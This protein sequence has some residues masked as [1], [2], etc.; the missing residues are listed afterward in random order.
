MKLQVYRAATALGG[1]LIRLYLARRRARG[2]EDAARFGER[3]GHPGR[4]RPPGPL[5]WLHGASVGESLSL[6]PLV[7]R[8]RRDLPGAAALVTTGTVTSARLMAER[9]PEGAFHQYVPVDRAAWVRTFLDH[10]RP[11]LIL[12]SESEFWPNLLCEPAAR[13]IPM[14]L[15]NGRVS[16]RALATWR[17]HRGL[18]RHLLAGFALCLGQSPRDAER[19]RELGAPRVDCL[20]NLKQAAAPLP[21]DAADLAALDAALDGRP[22]WLAASTHAGEEALAGRVHR[23]LA[24]RHPGLLT[25]VVPRH[26]DRGA[27]VAADLRRQGL[28]VA[29][30]GGGEAPAA[31]TDVLLADTLGELGLFYRLGGVAF[32]GKS[33]L[34]EGGQNPLEPAQLGCAVLYGPHMG[35]F[36]DTV[37]GLEAAGAAQAVADEAALA[38]AV[39]RLLAD[40]AERA[41]RAAAGAAFATARSAVLDDV[42]AALEPF[43]APL[44]AAAPEPTRAG[45]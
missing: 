40:P 44:R 41:R 7:Q 32:V 43:L 38:A 20:G 5:V 19:L 13:G 23:A 45:A 10:W 26:P 33:L 9:L 30:R 11:D 6:L 21:V 42:M 15:V 27:A 22:R 39:D 16:D 28:A 31:D 29:R 14:V 18:I 1:P 17:R 34:A 4:P 25:M 24:G 37:A 3:L 2:K 12:W 36:T 8:L 35:N